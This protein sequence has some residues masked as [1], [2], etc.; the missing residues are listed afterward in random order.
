MG[1][2]KTEGIVC[3]GIKLNEADRIVHIYTNN[4]LIR[5]VVK[6]VRKTKSKFGGR[7]E[8]I[9]YVNLV[10]YSGRSLDTVSQVELVDPY[11]HIKKDFIKL[12]LGLAMA[13]FV[14]RL[15]E[16]ESHP[17]E[18]LEVFKDSLDKTNN[19]GLA[20]NIFLLFNLRLLKILGY[21]FEFNICVYCG[22]KDG[23][24]SFS[25]VQ[26]G[27]VCRKCNPDDL[28]S[29]ENSL[30]AKALA[31]IANGSDASISRDVL[32][33]AV[34][35]IYNFVRYHLDINLKSSHFIDRILTNESS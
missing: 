25:S 30:A 28:V 7:L 27:M 2:Y 29:K 12:T 3:S 4:G 23:L 8:P 11:M 5:A 35:L 16:H 1:V 13:D 10:L 20:E 17:G 22:R 26:G 24:V 6:G 32:K 15:A 31:S 19:N 21:N 18:L 33:A 9:S 14:Q 34:K